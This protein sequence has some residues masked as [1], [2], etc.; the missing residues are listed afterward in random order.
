MRRIPGYERTH[1]VTTTHVHG[2]TGLEQRLKIG[3]INVATLRQK[4]EELV[5]MMKMRDLSILAVEETRMRGKG[6]KIIHE[7]YRLIYSGAEDNRHGVAIMVTDC[8]LR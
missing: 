4:E 3:T 7:N 1:S 6:D 8:P 2:T 5:E